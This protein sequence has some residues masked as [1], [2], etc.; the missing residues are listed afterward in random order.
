M[1]NLLVIGLLKLKWHIEPYADLFI[2]L[3]RILA[4]SNDISTL[5]KRS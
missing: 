2:Y 3:D 4:S 1:K 5:C